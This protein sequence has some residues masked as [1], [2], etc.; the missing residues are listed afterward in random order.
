MKEEIEAYIAKS[1]QIEQEANLENV[2]VTDH[3]PKQKKFTTIGQKDDE[4]FYRYQQSLQE[5]KND[6]PERIRVGKPE[7]YQRGSLLQK[8]FDPL[9]GA[10][11]LENG[12][13]FYKV[14]EA[15][16]TNI[17]NEEKLR[18]EWELLKAA[19]S[20][21]LEV[22]EDDQ[23]ELRMAL[24]D[25]MEKASP[26]SEDEFNAIL[27]KEFSVFKNGEEYDYVKDMRDAFATSLERPVAERIL[28]TIPEHV[29]WDIK[30]PRI[31]DP[32]KF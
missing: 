15:E 25:E 2:Y 28:D 9:A 10:E 4:Q 16:L 5:Y 14:D 29:F 26:F 12:A 6:M 24:L 32:Q 27:D 19:N 7:R 13:L 11:K 22:P 30:T 20:N 3:V 1:Y 31:A 17:D 8:V 23:D 18:A 21:V